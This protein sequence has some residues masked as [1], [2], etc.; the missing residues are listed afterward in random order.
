MEGVSPPGPF[1]RSA[2]INAAAVGDWDVAVIVDAD[3]FVKDMQQV[4]DA[5]ALAR[6]S[7]RVVF[8]FT[9]YRGLA[10]WATK[11]VLAGE[12]MPS[13]GAKRLDHESSVVVVPRIAWDTVGGYDDRFVGW[14]QEDVAFAQAV[15]VLCGEPL[16]VPGTVYHLYHARSAEKDMRLPGYQMNQ[17]LGA[18]YRATTEPEGMM[19]LL[20]GKRQA[21]FHGI[22][23]A[24]AWRG[25]E[26]RSGPGSTT[27]STAGAREFIERFCTEVGARHVLD[28]ACGASSWMPELPG[29]RGVDIVPAAV[30][31]MQRRFPGRA[32]A[33]ADICA[34]DLGEADVVI[35]RDVLAHLSNED[36]LLALKNVRSTGA[37]YLVATTFDGADNAHDTRTG[38]YRE[39]DLRYEPF[40]LGDPV[41][42]VADGYWERRLKFPTKR[43][44]AWKL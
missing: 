3:V 24:N 6:S 14:G 43:L 44:A 37:R 9:E 40:G 31:D 18:A 25:K 27:L 29:Y 33:V 34:D 12:P 22:F 17:M 19:A 7:G 4:R 13:V 35:M 30:A 38:G 11:R 23:I 42:S 26:T 10:H 21:M 39:V 1:N 28:A 16:R 32:Y 2:A 5:V 8:A 15:R 20:A 36:A 41:R